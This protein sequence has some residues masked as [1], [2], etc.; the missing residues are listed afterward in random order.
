[1]SAA[2]DMS[3]THAQ[4]QQPRDTQEQASSVPPESPKVVPTVPLDSLRRKGA[5]LFLQ[6]I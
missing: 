2:A 1:M 5:L 6:A 3:H 4:C